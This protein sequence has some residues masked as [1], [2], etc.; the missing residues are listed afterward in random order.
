MKCKA[1]STAENAFAFKFIKENNVAVCEVYLKASEAIS[2]LKTKGKGSKRKASRI[3][4]RCFYKTD[5][6]RLV[7]WPKKLGVWRSWEMIVFGWIYLFQLTI[8]NLVVSLAV[9]V[10][11]GGTVAMMA[12]SLFKSHLEEEAGKS[13][14]SMFFETPASKMFTQS[15]FR[16][17]QTFTTFLLNFAHP[18]VDCDVGPWGTWT[19]G[20]ITKHKVSQITF[21]SWYLLWIQYLRPYHKNC[22]IWPQTSSQ[23]SKL[24]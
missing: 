15:N 23:A 6:Q 22:T 16:I 19:L 5:L 3:E 1:A 4:Q 17:H 18:V 2:S 21:F 8:V 20:C 7:Q 24:R 10:L 13:S 11:V 14:S 9:L 12:L